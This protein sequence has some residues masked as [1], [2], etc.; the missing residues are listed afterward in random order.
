MS[1][2]AFDPTGCA[3]SNRVIGES[4]SLRKDP[5]G[6][7]LFAVLTQG[8]FFE[9]GLGVLYRPRDGAERILRPN[10]DYTLA[11]PY[12]DASRKLN[13]RVFGAISL[14]DIT[15][16]G[17][18]IF[19]AQLFGGPTGLTQVQ[20]DTLML[21]TGFHPEYTT[22]EQ[23][24]RVLG[25]DP[26]T[27]PSFDFSWSKVNVDQVK[28]TVESLRSAG[29]SV[30]MRPTLL[31]KPE[32]AKFI[33]TAE[34]V[35]LGLTPNYP[36]AT[37]TQALA[38]DAKSLL[39]PAVFFDALAPMVR[40]HLDQLGYLIPIPFR[41]GI[42]VTARTL[43][44]KDTG[45]WAPRLDQPLPFT[46]NG[47]FYINQW[48]LVNNTDLNH[49]DRVMVKVTGKEP[50]LPTGAK[51][52]NLGVMPPCSVQ[53]RAV[54]NV[55]NDLQYKID[56]HL[57]QANLYVEY[58]LGAGDEID[59]MWKPIASRVSGERPY[60]RV[61]EVT[62]GERTFTLGDL[63]YRKLADLRVTI[64]DAVIL[65]PHMNDYTLDAQGRLVINYRLQLGDVIE[66]EDLDHLPDVGKMRA[67]TD[68][69]TSYSA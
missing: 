18:V 7:Y 24:L 52:F 32:A 30:Q 3:L 15:L 45:I 10:V 22:W 58:P 28:E 69:M 66:V 19:A 40:D 26:P 63:G 8:P 11:L 65:N 27:L 36:A 43:V 57:D 59:L 21:S 55:F 51:V 37:L 1:A 56:Y 12:L 17:E 33:P 13:T 39:T 5:S 23:R 4:V 35:G 9:Q 47:V 46:T 44:L 64:N 31:D 20:R 2:Y 38:K 42:Q 50:T 49:W 54:L 41:A 48:M 61:I 16:E 6:R 60:Y 14:T 29:L 67:R 34:E 62:S 68:A 53:T 25:I